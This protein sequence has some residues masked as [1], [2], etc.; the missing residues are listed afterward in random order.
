ML[1]I[2]L[3]NI[4]KIIQ[5]YKQ[6]VEQTAVQ[7][8]LR[9]KPTLLARALLLHSPFSISSLQPRCSYSSLKG[10]TAA[11]MPASI[12]PSKIP[13]K[14]PLAHHPHDAISRGLPCQEEAPFL[15]IISGGDV[16]KNMDALF[17]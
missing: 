8:Q 13:L 12:P 11:L 1:T 9:L 4:V 16:L 15:I 10:D 7:N 14:L 5:L 6:L 2:F 3:D 17:A